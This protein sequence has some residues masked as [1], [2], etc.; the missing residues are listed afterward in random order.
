[1][2][3]DEDFSVW[4]SNFGQTTV[5]DGSG[6]LAPVAAEAAA[7]SARQHV[8]RCCCGL[9]LSVAA[10]AAA[11]SVR[12]GF[13]EVT[14]PPLPLAISPSSPSP[15]PSPAVNIG[16]HT[17]ASPVPDAPRAVAFTSLRFDDTRRPGL[18]GLLNKPIKLAPSR[19]VDETLSRQNLLLAIELLADR[20]VDRDRTDDLA[21]WDTSTHGRSKESSNQVSQLD[22]AWELWERQR[23]T[24]RPYHRWAPG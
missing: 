14:T 4:R 5:T 18:P 12:Q 15:N 6:S 1:L 17:P 11:T 21:P 16:S 9:C 10:D 23:V 7:T 2:V 19:D 20:A 3:D 13:A 8:P 24:F 22:L